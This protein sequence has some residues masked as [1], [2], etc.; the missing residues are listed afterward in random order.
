MTSC[1]GELSERI[2]ELT[3]AT[4]S[5][6]EQV[7]ELKAESAERA[8]TL[9]AIRKQIEHST[10]TSVSVSGLYELSDVEAIGFKAK[11]DKTALKQ[12]SAGFLS[13]TFLIDD[14]SE[15]LLEVWEG[16]FPF[17]GEPNSV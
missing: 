8:E 10:E 9:E 13:S 1:T 3:F 12:L 7:Q 11:K 5:L 4:N 2:E 15:G 14:M 16:S 6:Q 17:E